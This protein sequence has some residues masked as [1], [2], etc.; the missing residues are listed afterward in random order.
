MNPFEGM[1]V[2]GSV[3]LTVLA[4][5]G[6]IVS[7][8][9]LY[10]FHVGI[11]AQMISERRFLMSMIL[12]WGLALGLMGFI[13][14]ITPDARPLDSI[15]VS[16]NL[17]YLYL[18]GSIGYT[19]YRLFSHWMSYQDIVGDKP[20]IPETDERISKMVID[21]RLICH[22]INN[23]LQE[24]VGPIEIL[25][26]NGKLPDDVKI[27]L[28][29]LFNRIVYLSKN[30]ETVHK[31]VKRIGNVES[32]NSNQTEIQKEEETTRTTDNLSDCSE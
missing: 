13:G 31:L 30:V 1:R 6:M 15:S 24:I 26:E 8:D 29:T 18:I 32:C 28:E 12:T 25:K 2:V 10:A 21:S 16:T 17:L 14:A 27:E 9:G 19:T 11:R 23:I 5:W 7:K 3:I 4:C 20:L 22:Q